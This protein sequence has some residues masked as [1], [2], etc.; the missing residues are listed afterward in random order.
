MEKNCVSHEDEIKDDKKVSS[1][2]NE[3]TNSSTVNY[4][5]RKDIKSRASKI[6]EN[7]LWN[8]FKP[9]LLLILISV[10]YTFLLT[11]FKV[12]IND[13]FYVIYEF[14]YSLVVTPIT[15]GICAYTLAIIR[16]K[17]FSLKLVF[18]E[19]KNVVIIVLTSI[20]V[21]VFTFLWTLL[22]VVPG[23][24]ASL[25]YSLVYYL[26]ADKD[27]GGT[28]TISKSKYMMKGYKGNYLLFNLSFIP[29][30]LLVIITFGIASIYVVPYMNVSQA[31]YYEE[32][33]KIK[34]IKID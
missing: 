30:I 22:L 31:L 19:Y 25:S 9:S 6:L 20:L 7:N 29:W 21:F 2:S 32:L 11:I 26:L 10:L 18:S 4:I 12:D 28:D 1:N 8:I 3:E 34:S 13:K 14:I 5:N 24:I 33:K 15:V 17:P 23:I 16:K 27:K